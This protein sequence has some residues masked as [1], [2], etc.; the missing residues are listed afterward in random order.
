MRSQYK[1]N[2]FSI[3]TLLCG[4]QQTIRYLI[5]IE[6]TPIVYLD[7]SPFIQVSLNTM[8]K[9]FFFFYSV[10]LSFLQFLIKIS[11]MNEIITLLTQHSV[12]HKIY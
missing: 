6:H 3:T 9:K 11:S 8:E 4:E 10:F 1:N 12:G 5:V 7:S 2:R